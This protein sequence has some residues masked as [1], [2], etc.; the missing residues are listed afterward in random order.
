MLRT[1]ASWCIPIEPVMDRES[2]ERY[3]IL[4]VPCADCF[5][6]FLV[7]KKKNSDKTRQSLLIGISGIVIQKGTDKPLTK[8]INGVL[9]YD[10]C[11]PNRD[12]WF[13]VFPELRPFG[14]MDAFRN[15][16]DGSFKARFSDL[17]KEDHMVMREYFIEL[18][19]NAYQMPKETGTQLKFLLNQALYGKVET[20]DA[21]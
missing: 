10:T 5:S 20:R 3:D 9:R 2:N 12:V 11:T 19:L 1:G 14:I 8:E 16:Y 7:I 15:I 6:P 21:K 18:C 13:K 17:T 4:W